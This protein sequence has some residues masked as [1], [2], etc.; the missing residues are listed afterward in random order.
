MSL[1]FF[2]RLRTTFLVNA[3]FDG[4]KKLAKNSSTLC[5][6]EPWLITAREPDSLLDSLDES[7]GSVHVTLPGCLPYQASSWTNAE[8]A[9]VGSVV[10]VAPLLVASLKRR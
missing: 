7:A 9:S 10:D 6:P 2:F 4:G 1:T 3:A 5:R 8:P